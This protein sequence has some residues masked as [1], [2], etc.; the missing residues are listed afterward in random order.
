MWGVSTRWTVTDCLPHQRRNLRRSGREQVCAT[1]IQ[2]LI[3][4]TKSKL[5]LTAHRQYKQICHINETVCEISHLLSDPESGVL[6]VSGR[7]PRG[8][9]DTVGVVGGPGR[10]AAAPGSGCL[11]EGSRD[12][13]EAAR[14]PQPQDRLYR[15]HLGVPARGQ[16]SLCDPETPCCHCTFT[17]FRVHFMVHLLHFTALISPQTLC[18]GSA[19]NMCFHALRSFAQG[20]SDELLVSG[21]VGL[22]PALPPGPPHRLQ[23][24]LSLGLCHGGV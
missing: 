13:L 3:Y 21:T 1:E 6:V 11:P 10:P 9:S 2:I 19:L 18:R 12:K 16:R 20:V 24:V 23:C 22:C 7:R 8:A 4:C 14:A 5:I 17:P 15:H